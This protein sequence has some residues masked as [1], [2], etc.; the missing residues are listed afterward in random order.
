M[1]TTL[2]AFNDALLRRQSVC[3]TFISNLYSIQQTIL[4]LTYRGR[5]QVQKSDQNI[6]SS[7][8]KS[9]SLSTFISTLIPVALVAGFMTLLFLIL[10]R[11][12]RRQY[13]PRTYL[14]SL[15]EQ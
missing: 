10:R 13:S 14:G 6:G 2:H 9:N 3:Y 15:R 8:G 12:Y 4:V 11:R 7:Q 1:D 5:V